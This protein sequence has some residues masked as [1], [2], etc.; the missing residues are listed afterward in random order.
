[1]GPSLM[2]RAPK[3]QTNTLSFELSSA[4]NWSGGSNFRSRQLI[5][6]ELTF[7]CYF[8]LATFLL[9]R[10]LV[11]F[12]VAFFLVALRFAAFFFVVF[13][14]AVLVAFFLVLFFAM[15]FPFIIRSELS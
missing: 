11:A 15:A 10:F 5:A 2:F 6:T 14:A 12:L 8:F 4:I 7:G 9:A 3:R 1:M 13:F